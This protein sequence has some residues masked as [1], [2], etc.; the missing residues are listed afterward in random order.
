[1]PDRWRIVYKYRKE[2]NYILKRL[3]AV[4]FI[5]LPAILIIGC[6]EQNEI[7]EGDV[8]VNGEVTGDATGTDKD[9]ESDVKT[10]YLLLINGQSVAYISTETDIMEI[11]DQLIA[12]KKVSLSELHSEIVKI[13]V[14]SDI[15]ISKASCREDEIVSVE[16][17]IAG[18]REGGGSISFLYTVNEHETQL[19][20]FETVYK[21]SS[22]YYEGKQVVQSAG[23][24]GEKKLTYEVTYLDGS[25]TQR[26]LSQEKTVKKPQ[27]K[28]VLVGTKK[29]TASTG[30]YMWPTKSVYVTSHYGP[31]TLNGKYD[32]HIGIDLRAAVGTDI[33]AADGG[34]VIYTGYLGSYGYLIRIRHDNGDE[35]YY[36][37]MSK[38]SVSTGSRVYKGQVIGKSGISGNVT[39]PHLHFEIRKNG[40]TVN[41]IYYLPKI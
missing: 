36:A 6:S 5:L 19:I 2:G 9:T 35:T 13:T 37:H 22:A 8:S 39:G 16:E 34:K 21:N 20:N 17:A 4:L 12:E 28:V 38:I 29:S 10:A 1:M 15:Q 3:F 31:R 14:E 33:Y 27:N 32:Y 23:V 11:E 26:E 30:K 41:P 18:Y 25:E 24:K 7:Q 40:K